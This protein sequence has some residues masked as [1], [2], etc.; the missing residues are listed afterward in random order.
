ML[1]GKLGLDDHS[2]DAQQI[3]VAARDSGIEVVYKGIRLT[4]ARI[5]DA[6]LEEGVHIVGLSILCGSHMPLVK[7]FLRRMREQ[8]IGEVTVVVGGIIPAEGTKGLQAAG[9]ACAG[10]PT[11]SP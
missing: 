9:M 7:E 8:G 11:L 1:I 4:P 2:N 3:A 6:A 5:A 10:A